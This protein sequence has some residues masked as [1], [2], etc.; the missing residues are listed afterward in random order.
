MG[1]GEIQF[2]Y[3]RFPEPYESL[4]KQVF[5]DS[6]G[7]S[8]PDVARDVPQGSQRALD[9]LG[10]RTTA[11]IFGLV[12]TVGGALEVG[13]WWEKISP[14][15]DVVLPMVYPSHYP[16]GAFG[17]ASP[18][19]GAVQSHHDRDHARAGARREA[20]HHD[21]R[22]R[23]PV[24]AGVLARQAA[25]RASARSRSR[26]GRCTTRATTAGCCG[27]RA[28]STSRSCRRWRRR[29]CRGRRSELV[30]WIVG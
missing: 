30:S 18:E 21:G 9:K 3:I 1:F 22:A 25:V 11:D 20:R 10:V 8:K 27:A 5:P 4:P 16:R 29:W 23:A 26:S 7:V 19:R 15:V 17:I 12:T 6:N 28:R 14:T 2:D 24:A 13:Q